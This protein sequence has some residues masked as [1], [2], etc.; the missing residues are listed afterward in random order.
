MLPMNNY[1]SLSSF[2]I[3]CKMVFKTQFK[4]WTLLCKITFLKQNGIQMVLNVGYGSSFFF[5]SNS[6]SNFFMCLSLSS[7][8]L[9]HHHLF[10]F[11]FN[12]LSFHTHKTRNWKGNWRE[13]KGEDPNPLTCMHRFGIS[14][15]SYSNLNNNAYHNTQL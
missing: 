8:L 2:Y 13:T 14:C 4:F 15:K 3:N 12:S 1:T 5:F 11:N 7:F 9:S 10:I 6:L